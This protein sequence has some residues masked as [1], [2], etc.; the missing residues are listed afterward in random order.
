MQYLKSNWHK[1]I[2]DI[3]ILVLYWSC[4]DRLLSWQQQHPGL[5]CTVLMILNIAAIA[6]GCFSFF[7]LY[8]EQSLIESYRKSLSKFEMG[9][10]GLSAFISALGFLWW[11]AP[12]SAVKKLGVQDTGFI[13]GATAYFVTYMAI[14]ARSITDSRML[15]LAN[16]QVFK[17]TTAIFVGV[18]FFFS[19]VFLLMTFQRWQPSFMGARALAVICLC[20]FY[21]PLRIFLLLRP[22]YHKFELL[23]FALAFIFMLFKLLGYF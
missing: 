20:V 11:L 3:L 4:F 8:A 15:Q 6:L 23:S 18:F 2:P 21:L 22:P 5:S 19:Y 16:S 10:I 7:S 17:L 13:L 14:V 1:F 12:F 9:V